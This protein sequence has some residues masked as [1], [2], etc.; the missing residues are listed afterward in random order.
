MNRFLLGLSALLIPFLSE[1][2][3]FFDNSLVHKVEINF[4]DDNWDHLLDSV[5][6]DSPGTGSGTGRILA[7]VSINGTAFDSC[8]VRYLSLIH[9]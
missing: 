7:Q 5:A 9:I 1:A 2:Q 8:G 6:S 4:Y 3:S